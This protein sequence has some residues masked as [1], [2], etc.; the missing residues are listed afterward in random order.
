MSSSHTKF[1]NTEEFI[2]TVPIYK[3]FEITDDYIED[4][5]N[6]INF[7]GNIDA[8]CL[9][10]GKSS[11]FH[12]ENENYQY[13]RSA[14]KSDRKFELSFTC[15]RNEN[16]K[17]IFYFCVENNQMQKIGQYPSLAN[18][19]TPK[20]KKYR[21]ILGEEKYTEFNRA[22]GLKAHGVGIGSFVY[23]RRI[24]EG[25]IEEAHT[26]ATQEANWDEDKYIKAKMLEKVD[27]LK[28]VLPELLIQNKIVYSVLSKGIHE[29]SE[30]E[31]LQYFDVVQ[32][33][34]E[35]FLDEKLEQQ[36]RK[37]KLTNAKKALEQIHQKI[38]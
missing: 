8:Y 14:V 13:H 1:P 32:L 31:C 3:S 6:L 27:L 21:K 16:H 4:A 25:L 7:R 22:I 30:D 23:L 37:L 20:L 18:H 12:C 19:Y 35:V 9:S 10:C 28:N 26:L 17:I 24:F 34:I 11:T 38:S 15:S 29:L 36:E 33:F 5:L 2:L